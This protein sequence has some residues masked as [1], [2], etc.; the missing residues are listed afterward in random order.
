[1]LN[2]NNIEN[3]L[4]NEQAQALVRMGVAGITFA[5]LC[6]FTLV[7]G[8]GAGAGSFNAA[9]IVGCYFAFSALWYVGLLRATR[10]STVR[11]YL[12]LVGDI[13]M[14]SAAMYLAGDIGAFFYPV[15]QWVI[16]GHGVRFGARR[17]VVSSALSVAFFALIIAI[18]PYWQHNLLNASGLLLGLVILPLYFLSLMRK[19]HS[20][21]D[22]LQ[23]ELEK[24]LHAASHDKLTG[25]P[26]RH[27]FYE[28]LDQEFRRARRHS[29]GYAVLFIDLDGFKR[30]N[31]ELGHHAGDEAL[32][33]IADRLARCCRDTDLAARLGG[34]EFAIILDSANSYE[35]ASTPAQRAIDLIEQPISIMGEQ[36]CLSASIGISLYPDDGITPDELTRN[37]DLAMYEVKRRGKRGFICFSQIKQKNVS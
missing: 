27:K 16:I 26:N 12:C 11:Q 15:Y 32:R 20:L 8:E 13:G 3:V 2:I 4:R 24:T 1:M 6:A 7:S 10:L 33:Q 28:R 14:I 22:K 29:S 9:V 23:V 36:R 37:A 35:Q 31:D 5:L 18:T 30:V 34:D 25:L 17:L 19:L 21:N